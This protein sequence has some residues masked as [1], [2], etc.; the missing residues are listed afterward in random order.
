LRRT[1]SQDI[2]LR[3]KDVSKKAL[4]NYLDIREINGI[5]NG[6][7][8]DIHTIL[9]SYLNYVNWMVD[10]RKTL[11]YFK[12]IQKKYSITSFRKIVY[13]IR[14][15]LFYLKFDW[16]NDIRPPAELEHTPK[17]V[18][19]EDIQNTLKYFENAD[20]V[21]QLNALILIGATSGLRST[22]LYQLNREDIDINNRIIY[23][24]HN[25]DNGQTTKNKKSRISFFTEEAR[26]ALINYYSL[27]EFDVTK[28]IFVKRQ[29]QNRF[30]SAP[31]KIKHLRKFFSQEWD[32]RGGPTSIKK[33][34][35]GHSLKSD[36]DLMH[37]N[38]QSEEDLK[39][40]YDKVMSNLSIG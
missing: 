30:Q 23:V 38:Y 12:Y 16:A 28:R 32:R 9:N 19:L 5:S 7:L 39:K 3:E 25:P 24:N 34:L 37:Y 2:F 10:E 40:I 35:M 29:C 27:G 33:I 4:L 1:G 22:E 17:R 31:I 21:L 18:G 26:K 20:V 8:S 15:F 11:D 6:W 14:K 36:V 13:Q